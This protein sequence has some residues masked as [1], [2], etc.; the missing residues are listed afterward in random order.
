MLYNTKKVDI[1]SDEMNELAS[2]LFGKASANWKR[3]RR[4]DLLTAKVEHLR[5]FESLMEK[6]NKDPYC[7]SEFFVPS[8]HG[9]KK[10]IAFNKLSFPQES[11]LLTGDSGS[12][13]SSFLELVHELLQIRLKQIQRLRQYAIKTGR[14]YWKEKLSILM[15]E[16][17]VLFFKETDLRTIVSKAV[18]WPNHQNE[19]AFYNLLDRISEVNYIIIDEAFYSSN[20][21]F[22]EN[23]ASEYEAY[24]KIYADLLISEKKKKGKIF[25]ASSNNTAGGLDTSAPII[26]RF[27]ELFDRTIFMNRVPGI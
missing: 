26:R 10:E 12:C 19:N 13:K 3:N 2:L 24:F 8:W 23:S 27:S 20:W 15:K 14:D 1:T 21:K 9:R 16:H 11:I 18:K 6:Y 4:F 7:L 5:T 17:S 25:L 22:P